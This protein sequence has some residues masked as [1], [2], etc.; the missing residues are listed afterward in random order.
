MKEPITEIQDIARR[1][2]ALDSSD[3]RLYDAVRRLDPGVARALKEVEFSGYMVSMERLFEAF[4]I[5]F[6]RSVCDS[7]VRQVA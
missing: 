7:P 6:L 2:A 5:E 1:L 4:H 3:D